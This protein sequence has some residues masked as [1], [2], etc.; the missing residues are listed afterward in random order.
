MVVPAAGCGARAGLNGNKILAD[1]KGRPLLA[2]TLESLAAA[3]LAKLDAAIVEWILCARPEEFALIE[4]AVPHHLAPVRLVE[5]GATRQES[6]YAGVKQASGDLVLV[7]DAARP[8]LD[9][10][11]MLRVVESALHNGAAIAA[12]PVSDTVKQTAPGDCFIARTL[13][14]STIWTAQTPQVFRRNLLL[15]ALESAVREDYQGTDCASLL[16]R[17]GT[18]VALV[19]GHY[20]NLKVTF[21]ADMERAAAILS[22]RLGS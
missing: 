12:L 4:A 13:D 16:E 3:P 5:G 14:R 21:A 19:E 11:T 1:L 7:H 6:V 15:H 8:C 2:W 17:K 9:D 22:A 10:G 20:T 18:P